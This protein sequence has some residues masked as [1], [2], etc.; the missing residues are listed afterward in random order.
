MIEKCW[1]GFLGR[2]A[3]AGV[4]E[5]H[6]RSSFAQRLLM[7]EA[8]HRQRRLMQMRQFVALRRWRLHAKALGIARIARIQARPAFTIGSRDCPAK[9]PPDLD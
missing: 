8:V 4:R 6:A 3:A 1:R 7:R 2:R 9:G 5:L